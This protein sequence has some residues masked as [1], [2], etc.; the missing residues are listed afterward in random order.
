MHFPHNKVEATKVLNILPFII[1]K[2]ILINPKNCMNRSGI[3]KATMGLWD[4]DKSTFTDPN[5]FH[6][7]KAMESMFEGTGLTAM[8]LDQDPKDYLNNQMGTFDEVDIQK[9]YARAQVK[10]DE[11]IT[12]ASRSRQIGRKM[13]AQEKIASPPDI[14][15]EPDGYTSITLGLTH[16]ADVDDDDYLIGCEYLDLDPAGGDFSLLGDNVYLPGG[17]VYVLVEDS[18]RVSCE[19]GH[20]SALQVKEAKSLLTQEFNTSLNK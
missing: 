10:D 16:G 13:Q 19:I 17:V 1:T 7:D 15:I 2:E 12:I 20:T 14:D 3:E 8:D 18:I 11:T 9:S 6:N 5:K 4:M